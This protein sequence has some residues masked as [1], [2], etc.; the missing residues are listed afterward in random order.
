MSEISGQIQRE[1]EISCILSR[2]KDIQEQMES[3]TK[4]LYEK[5]Q[6]SLSQVIETAPPTELKGT[7]KKPPQSDLGNLLAILSD[8]YQS[9]LDEIHDMI[10]RCQL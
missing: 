8:G 5:L 10:R 3:A 2:L 4:R 9:S 1:S 7:P 6:P